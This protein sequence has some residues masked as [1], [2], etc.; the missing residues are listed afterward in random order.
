MTPVF[1]LLTMKIYLQGKIFGSSDTVARVILKEDV[2]LY[3]CEDGDPTAGG[4]DK[5]LAEIIARHEARGKMSQAK[6]YL[7][8]ITK[9]GCYRKNMWFWG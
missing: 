1:S 4:I 2:P 9:M 6:S 5:V 8:T 3:L 7:K